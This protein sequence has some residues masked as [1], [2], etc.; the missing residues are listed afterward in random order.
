MRH[1]TSEANWRQPLKWDR[2]AGAA[3]IRK[4][5][6]CASLADVFD[7]AVP[8]QWRRDLFE[9]IART[10]NL[11]WLLLTKRIGNARRMMVDAL[12]Q[13]IRSDAP[14]SW[15][16]VWLGATVV[17]Q[18]EADRDI[19]KLLST[20][21]GVRFLSIEP[22]LGPIDLTAI[23]RTEAAGFMRPLDGR[24]ATI[25]WVI[26]GGESGPHARPMHPRWVRSIRN[27]C[28]A[29][30]VPFLFKQW[31]QYLPEDQAEAR[32]FGFETADGR[33]AH[34]TFPDGLAAVR[35]RHKADAGRVLDGMTHDEVPR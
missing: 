6:F 35:L 11:D 18:E 19:P 14:L 12:E 24:W 1:R 4:R 22:M 29:A 28:A 33:E 8:D 3:G 9:L 7:N 15:R 26:V 23:R 30:D 32:N 17:N 25:N 27:Q 5:V 21:A 34:I 2:E 20:P 13:T 31:G 10:Q 16:N